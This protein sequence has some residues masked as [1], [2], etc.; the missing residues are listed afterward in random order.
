M[1]Q[2]GSGVRCSPWSLRIPDGWHIAVKRAIREG[3]KGN[4]IEDV[5]ALIRLEISRAAEFSD[6]PPRWPPW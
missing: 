1:V 2:L 4:W 6:N 5:E 3:T